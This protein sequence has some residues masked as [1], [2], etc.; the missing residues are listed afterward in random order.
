MANIRVNSFFTI[1][2]IH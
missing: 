2:T 1:T